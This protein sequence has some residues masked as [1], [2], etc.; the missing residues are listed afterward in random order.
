MNPSPHKNLVGASIRKLRYQRGW[1]QSDLARKLQLLGLDISRDTIAKA[2]AQVRPVTDK[3]M[4]LLS[5]IFE[6]P[7]ADLYTGIDLDGWNS[8]DGSP[9]CRNTRREAWC[10]QARAA[11]GSYLQ[12]A[13]KHER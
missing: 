5:R 6:V 1:S 11:D 9:I 3:E 12:T 4:Y 10:A 2:E 8:L 13:F 7:V